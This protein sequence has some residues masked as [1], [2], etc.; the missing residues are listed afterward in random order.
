MILSFGY[1]NTPRCCDIDGVVHF[2]VPSFAFEYHSSGVD[3][4]H[5][6]GKFERQL[7]VLLD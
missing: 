6:V 5:I 2:Y 1:Q 7:D 4:H 3:D